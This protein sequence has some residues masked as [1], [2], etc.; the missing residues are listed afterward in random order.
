MRHKSIKNPDPLN[1]TARDIL[2]N[3]DRHRFHKDSSLEN[4]FCSGCSQI[5]VQLI[6]TKTILS[7]NS[8]HSPAV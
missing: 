2:L 5:N 7:K 3:C 8:L 1:S 4:L 6:K